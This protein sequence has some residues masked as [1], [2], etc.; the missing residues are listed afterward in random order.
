VI[1]EEAP[2]RHQ[3]GLL[4]TPR[5]VLAMPQATAA[6]RVARFYE[7][8]RA[9]FAR[10]DPPRPEGFFTEAY[11]R[12]RLEQAHAELVMDKGAR[13]FA[14][15]RTGATDATE[16]AV[17]G[18]VHF[19]LITRGPL[20]SAVLGYALDRAHVGRGLMVEAAG[21]AIAWAFSSLALHRLEASYVPENERSGRTLR[22]L[23]F[24]VDGYARDYL[25][26]DG[27]WRDH[28]RTSLTNPS[29]TPPAR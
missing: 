23:G 8:N 15:G 2:P 10:W 20:Q 18:M 1:A 21:A 24:Q 19:S 5:L 16:G 7:D 14:F 28:V 25:F 9:H 3:A 17:V 13:L 12:E 29:P 6:G 26:I 22:R 4:E 11:W 27:A